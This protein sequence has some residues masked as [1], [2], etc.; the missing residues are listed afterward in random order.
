M[1]VCT[2]VADAFCNIISPH[3]SNEVDL[4]HGCA[5]P[6]QKG[7]DG[8]N[9]TEYIKTLLRQAVVETLRQFGRQRDNFLIAT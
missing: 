7:V 6:A 5:T 4:C 8:P 2:D 3:E 9:S 1:T